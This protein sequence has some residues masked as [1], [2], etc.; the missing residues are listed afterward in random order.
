M[1][2]VSNHKFC[3]EKSNSSKMN[4]ITNWIASRSENEKSSIEIFNSIEI[5]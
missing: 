5:I 2:S 4:W 1:E 3:Y